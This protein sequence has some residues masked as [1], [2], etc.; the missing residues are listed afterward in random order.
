[1]ALQ[2]QYFPQS[3]PHPGETLTEK[4]EEME[5]GPKSLPFVPTNLKKQLLP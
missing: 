3:R 1:M 4:L 5:M 2:N